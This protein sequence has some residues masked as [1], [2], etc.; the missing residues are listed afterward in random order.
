MA[1]KKKQMVI[2]S[3]KENILTMATF[4]G[5][6]IGELKFIMKDFIQYNTN[7]R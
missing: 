6:L 3:L 7:I 2:N 1:G 5:V 4:L